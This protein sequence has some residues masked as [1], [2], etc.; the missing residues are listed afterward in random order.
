LFFRVPKTVDC[1][2]LYCGGWP[3]I[4]ELTGPGGCGAG[5]FSAVEE[6]KRA[7][8]SAEKSNHHEGDIR[9]LRLAQVNCCDQ[10]YKAVS[11][12]RLMTKFG[13]IGLGARHCWRHVFLLGGEGLGKI[14]LGH[15]F[16]A[17]PAAF[18]G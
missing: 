5:K 12:D 4:R 1:R 14:D 9:P 11:L 15:W 6:I 10:S 18:W 2:L 7:K 17:E 13:L 8:Q 3:G 16:E